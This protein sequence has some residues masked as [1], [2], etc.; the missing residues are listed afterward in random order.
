MKHFTIRNS[1]FTIA[2]CALALLCACKLNNA[3]Y[4]GTDQPLGNGAGNLPQAVATYPSSA[5]LLMD[6][7]TLADG[8][9][10][11]AELAF[12]Q[13]LDPGTVTAANVEVLNTTTS[14]V[15]TNPTLD[16]NAAARKLF[17]RNQSW[18]ANSAYLVT[19][20][21]SGIRDLQGNP[22]DGNANSRDDSTPY[23]NFLTTFYTSGS[24]PADCITTVPPR[25]ASIAPDTGLIDTAF[26]DIF[27]TFT[28]GMDTTALQNPANLTLASAAGIAQA[29]TISLVNPFQL[30]VRPA[31]RL[32]FGQVYTV[33]LKSSALKAF[34]QPNVP[35]CLA[36]LDAD[37][38]GAQ[39]HEPDFKWYFLVDSIPP[40]EVDSAAW[41]D[42]HIQIDFTELMDSGSLN[43]GTVQV[44]DSA[45]YV[46]GSVHTSVTFDGVTRV[47]YYFDRPQS[48][49]LRLLVSHTVKSTR[50]VMLDSNGNG[51]GGET[52][53]DYQE[54]IT[55]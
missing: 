26:P 39:A 10:G 2:V 15:V 54:T 9:Q 18:A 17:I 45:G 46:P 7:D 14:A 12:S 6:D 33:T 53:D 32:A 31:N 3:M 42:N 16:Y 52:A 24:G 38:N 29:L 20:K 13:Y 50:N 43:T 34:P 37:G 21:R 23:D 8:I 44:F 41:A 49:P 40:P 36:G 55:P 51:V 5:S 30:L 11:T 1:Q 25:I 35:A 27:V 4:D 48:F 19:L 47:D 22:L 28:Q